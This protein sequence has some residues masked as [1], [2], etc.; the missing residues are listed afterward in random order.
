[1]KNIFGILFLFLS[2]EVISQATCDQ[3][4]IN[5]A[6]MDSSGSQWEVSITFN[7][8]SADFI[9]YPYVLWMINAVG[10]TVGQGNLEYFGQFGQTTNVFHP[11]VMIGDPS[12]VGDIYFVYDAD[13]CVFQFDNLNSTNLAFESTLV[14]PFPNPAS[15]RIQF[16]VLPQYVEKLEL[17]DAAGR[18]IQNTARVSV[19][20]VSCLNSGI[21]HY[22]LMTTHGLY[23]GPILIA[24]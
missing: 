4:T 17:M 22:R 2:M 18:L 15:D 7:G 3:F 11:S 5:Q 14:L 13:T 23:S 6:Q 21:Y 9:N 19:L 1:M 24:R 20:E 10:D 12:F 16:N 8:N